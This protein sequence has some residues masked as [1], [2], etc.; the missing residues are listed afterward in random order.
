M[1]S[2]AR[3]LLVGCNYPGSTAELK[4]CIN[5]VHTMKSLLVNIYGF[6]EQDITV[7]IDTDSTYPKPTGANIKV[8]AAT[9]GLCQ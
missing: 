4:G 7:M 1:A 9:L 6:K 8:R 2:Q 3:A 5:D